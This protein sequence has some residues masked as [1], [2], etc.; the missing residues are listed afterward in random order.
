MDSFEAPSV[1]KARIAQGMDELTDLSF[2]AELGRRAPDQTDDADFSLGS[3][4]SQYYDQ[5]DVSRTP[6]RTAAPSA[7][8]ST[9]TAS[10]PTLQD[11]L[12][13]ASRPQAA[14]SLTTAMEQVPA[15]A[16]ESLDFTAEHRPELSAASVSL[17]PSRFASEAPR[18]P[19][20]SPPVA[21]QQDV[22]T[23]AASLSLSA[24][25]SM[26]TPEKDVPR[27]PPLTSTPYA[28]SLAART[29]S[30]APSHASV[31]A[32]RYSVGSSRARQSGVSS[33][34]ASSAAWRS[35]RDTPARLEPDAEA[36]YGA[37]VLPP[38]PAAERLGDESSA[39]SANGASGG[40]EE[41][42]S[43]QSR[44]TGTMHTSDI[45]STFDVRNA[46]MSS[47]DD[48]ARPS[49]ALSSRSARSANSE[50]SRSVRQ[51]ARQGSVASARSTQAVEDAP[52]A[53]ASTSGS[54]KRASA[55][56]SSAG[57][58]EAGEPSALANETSLGP[59]DETQGSSPAAG[60]LARQRQRQERAQSEQASHANGS[61]APSPPQGAFTPKAAHRDTERMKS[62]L[63]NTVRRSPIRLG[64]RQDAPRG[65][66]SASASPN[67][68]SSSSPNTPFAPET[69]ATRL[70]KA[71]IFAAGRTPLPRASPL[72]QA[73]PTDNSDSRSE[74]SSTHDLTGIARGMRPNT[75]FPGIGVG[76][77]AVPAAS[78]RVEGAMLNHYLH[79]V[80]TGLEQENVILKEQ[81]ETLERRY[82]A[83]LRE[84]EK[85][86]E[87]GPAPASDAKESGAALE[88]AY[89]R[90]QELEDGHNELNDLIDTAEER[91]AELLAELKRYRDAGVELPTADG[92]AATATVTHTGA[93]SEQQARV[94]NLE[95][96]LA[97]RAAQLQ[98]AEAEIQELRESL[99]RA[100]QSAS[101]RDAKLEALAAEQKAAQELA[102]RAEDR[103][104]ELETQLKRSREERA[105]LVR[106]ARDGGSREEHEELARAQDQYANAQKEADELRDHVEQLEKEL[107]ELRAV[108]DDAERDRADAAKLRERCAELEEQDARWADQQT[109]LELNLEDAQNDLQDSEQERQALADELE[110]AKRT[111]ASEIKDWVRT[112]VCMLCHAL[113]DRVAQL[114]EIAVEE[115]ESEVLKLRSQLSRVQQSPVGV[116]RPDPRDSAASIAQEQALARAQ[117]E[118]AALKARL[119]EHGSAASDALD[120]QLDLK[121]EE[122]A[123]LRRAKNDL[124]ERLDALKEQQQ[125]LSFFSAGVQATPGKGTP[126]HRNIMSLRTPL[127]TPG[128][129]PNLAPGVSRELLLRQS[130][131]SHA[132]LVQLSYADSTLHDQ[133]VMERLQQLQELLDAAN[134]SIDE[135]LHKLDS[136]DLSRLTLARH[137]A[138]ARKRIAEV[139]AELAALRLRS[140]DR[141]VLSS[142]LERVRCPGCKTKVNAAKHLR[143]SVG[144]SSSMRQSVGDVTSQSQ[145]SRTRELSMSVHAHFA[146]LKKQWALDLERIKRERQKETEEVASERRR[147]NGERGALEQENRALRDAASKANEKVEAGYQHRRLAAKRMFEGTEQVCRLFR[148]RRCSTSDPC[149]RLQVLEKSRQAVHALDDELREDRERISALQSRTHDSHSAGAIAEE[150]LQRLEIKLRTVETELARKESAHERLR[151]EL[152]RRSVSGMELPMQ[153]HELD[154]EVRHA[155]VELEQLRT[156]RAAVIAERSKLH[157]RV[158]EANDVSAAEC[159]S[160]CVIC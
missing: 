152:S 60:R 141:E 78:G 25:G 76:T 160:E 81:R 127:R 69:R 40:E 106:A 54:V 72:G 29:L 93:S 21:P 79:K 56:A 44:A 51:P 16:D 38:A 121:D 71:N 144:H 117:E 55:H 128:S 43:E 132:S 126:M 131:R 103:A 75:S 80:N 70:G 96:E 27:S 46:R 23:P 136:Q 143:E 88:E 4:P 158:R 14:S 30:F 1:L 82:N 5:Q 89:E 61:P 146:E 120:A 59:S 105:A 58:R 124:E 18:S 110:E 140:V 155:V 118:V 53:A 108:V 113:A 22:H 68:G 19:A 114:Q 142:R 66:A 73:T 39:T 159:A 84:L 125:V 111:H 119:A 95:D 74:V 101:E 150:Q 130:D 9:K 47:A 34:G 135:Q 28:P 45:V 98:D 3:E 83:A 6:G 123:Q 90:I 86:K 62:Y 151:G 36:S 149:T 116:R 32:P 2:E 154:A 133:P 100:A 148:R 11:A 138:D 7:A 67:A 139:E 65:A 64:L 92:A 129:P 115:K 49:S 134:N 109:Q 97:D 52:A 147:W 63:L 26:V 87:A 20:V 33:A 17:E 104:D 94:E 57:A 77:G 48:N 42:E 24:S 112:G 31:T 15:E 107:E 35:A 102:D 122:I 99:D 85:M 157:S 37:S 10:G 137:L 41:D 145:A 13:A 153:L 156:E 91:E 12:A 50:R 8:S